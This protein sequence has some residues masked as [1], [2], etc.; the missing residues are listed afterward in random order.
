MSCLCVKQ[1]ERGVKTKELLLLIKQKQRLLL[2]E[3]KK[4]NKNCVS[5]D[6]KN[7]LQLI[8]WRR[9]EEE[10]E[11]EDHSLLIKVV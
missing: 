2:K 7:F 8:F 5:I 11:G 1:G 4:K 10:R 6:K 3:S 9:W